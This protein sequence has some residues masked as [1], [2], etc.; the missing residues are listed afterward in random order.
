MKVKFV[1]LGV[2]ATV[3]GISLSGCGGSETASG[4]SDPV[5]RDTNCQ[6]IY[7]W[8]GY[9]QAPENEDFWYT[10]VNTYDFYTLIEE[11]VFSKIKDGDSS[12]DTIVELRGL[13]YDQ[14]LFNTPPIGTPVIESTYKQYRKD[15][16]ASND[17]F[18]PEEDQW[19]I[20]NS[21][22]SSCSRF[23]PEEFADEFASV[24]VMDK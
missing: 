1:K 5:V 18:M 23:T 3:L 15:D 8:M 16:S 21:L 13:Q 11:R 12:Y 9:R 10:Q 6:L 14:N 7:D 24:L 20:I 17:S 4:K 2:L 22:S 19:K